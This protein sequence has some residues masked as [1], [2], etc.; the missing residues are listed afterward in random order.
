MDYS[1]IIALALGLA[2]DAFAVSISCGVCV[3]KNRY[4]NAI[5]VAL[6]LEFSM[7]N[8]FIGL[9]SRICIQNFY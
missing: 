7:G 9:V 3:V 1:F 4:W 5:R 8:V 6:F 2:M